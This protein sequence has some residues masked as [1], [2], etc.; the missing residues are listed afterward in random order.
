MQCV[1]CPSCTC[2]VYCHCVLTANFKLLLKSRLKL[3]VYAQLSQPPQPPLSS[4][5]PRLATVL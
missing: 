1:C 5:F 4:P 3:K 2:N